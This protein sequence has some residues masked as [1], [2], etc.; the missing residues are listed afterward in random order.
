[1]IVRRDHY[2][3]MLR[4]FRDEPLVKIITGI[5]RCGKSTLMEMFVSDLKENGVPEKSIIH[6]NFEDHENSHITD[7]DTLLNEVKSKVELKKGTY[8]FFDEIQDII[9]WEKAINSMRYSGADV[10]ITGS[11]AKLLVSDFST[12]LSGRYVEIE[13]YPLSFR[14]YVKFFDENANK[15]QLLIDYMYTGGLPYV[16]SERRN[17]RNTDMI[18]SAIFNTV[19]VKDVVEKND[20]RDVP[21]LRNITRFVMKN[22][23][24]LTSTRSASAYIV[25]KGGKISPPT[26]DAYL[27]HLESAYLIHRARKYD[28]KKK[29]HLHT[30]S[31]FYVSDLGIGNNVVG[32][33]DEDISGMIENIVFMELLFRGKS[34]S[35]G[36][37][38]GKEIDLIASNKGERE[39]YQVTV[40]MFSPDVKE[41]ETKPLKMVNDNFPKTIITL[42]RYPSKNIDGI[43][44]IALAD[45]L[46]EDF[47]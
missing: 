15:D 20:I 33:E 34:V 26:V 16:A 11:N 47:Q 40:E 30:S 35:V 8:L 7:S 42:Q 24:N 29:E 32:Y 22:I 31:K 9:G 36:N 39:Y 46:L 37:I 14:E 21:A 17:E 38:N 4:D 12:Y 1:M 41:R 3:S 13:M 5:R 10:Y 44:V 28:L 27:K 45:F 25:S 19:F 2:L 43:K 6:M 23:G 18:L